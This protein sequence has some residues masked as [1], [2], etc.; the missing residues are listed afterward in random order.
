[1]KIE[2]EIKEEIVDGQSRMRMDQKVD[3]QGATDMEIRCCR[4]LRRALND[5]FQT[6]CAVEGGKV[7]ACDRPSTIDPPPPQLEQPPIN[8][9]TGKPFISDDGK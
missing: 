5:G 8:P 1:M 3:A 4:L 7:V 9:G 6:A 2:V